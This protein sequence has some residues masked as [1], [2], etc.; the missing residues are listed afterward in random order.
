MASHRSSMNSIV[1]DYKN[2]RTIPA[3]LGI[4]FA[5]ASLYQ[6]G[7]IAEVHLSWFD[8]TLTT[9]HAMFASLTVL[10]VAFMSSETKEFRNYEDWEKVVIAA[11]PALII[12]HQYWN[13][14]GDHFATH[15]PT[16]P[17]IGF[18]IAVAAW[19]VAVR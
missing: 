1:S 11:G 15:D 10:V 14:L 13:W 2:L 6:F 7:G 19:G 18:L 5:V 4:L 3:L 8:Y 16:L 17:V 12:L 9:K